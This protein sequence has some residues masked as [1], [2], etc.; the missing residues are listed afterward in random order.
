MLNRAILAVAV[1]TLGSTSAIANVADSWTDLDPR[2]RAAEYSR[3]STSAP[4][5][6]ASEQRPTSKYDALDRSSPL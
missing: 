6:Q 2:V 3:A 5:S 1:I 4:A